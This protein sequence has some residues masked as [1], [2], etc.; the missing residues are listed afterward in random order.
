[1]KGHVPTPD[2]IVDLMV[3]KLFRGRHPKPSDVVLDPGCG[4]GPFIA[5]VL[6]YCEA[7]RIRPPQ[8]VGVEQDPKHLTK[9]RARFKGVKNVRLVEA[10]YLAR[11][12]GPADFI[13]GNPPYVAITGLSYQ[14]KAAYRRK[15]LTAVGRFD[16]YILFFERSLSNLKPNGRLCFI[17]PEKFEYVAAAAP[18]R[19]L[20]ARHHV[21]EIH[22]VDEETF[23]SLVTFPAITTVSS[24][25][26]ASTTVVPRGGARRVVN[27]PEDGRSW[28][29]C[30]RGASDLQGRFT[31]AQ[32]ADRI[33]CGVA[34]GCDGVFI[35]P[36]NSLPPALRRFAH[37]TIAG[38]QLL[39]QGPDDS[40][41]TSDVIL[42]PY[43]SRG[44][45]LPE[46]SLGALED[47]L[48]PHEARLRQ[49][50]CVTRAGRVYYRFHDNFPIR[51]LKR[52]KIVWKDIGRVPRFW[53]DPSGAIAPRHTVY[54]LIP[55]AGID[56][57]RL[58]TYLNS[59]EAREWMEAHCQRAANGFLRLQSAVLRDLPVPEDVAINPKHCLTVDAGA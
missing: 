19:T 36:A 58:Q 52:P 37:P 14:E 29:P 8:M 28:A 27:L 2:S 7:A 1:M 57:K 25:S 40:L 13:I 32:V 39:R 20:L 23:G 35:Q 33:S 16:L 5:G 46:S 42:A 48:R 11:P 44:N 15:Y 12:F 38:R 30:L 45:L 26:P 4:D 3:A 34:T 55:K 9:A 41:E 6:R 47:Y 49:R 54:Y 21:E 18:L 24:T 10:D 56:L 31:L 17:T 22:H 43:D 59:A 53:A 51:D 50:T